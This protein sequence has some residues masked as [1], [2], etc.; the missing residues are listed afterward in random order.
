MP[1][2]VPTLKLPKPQFEQQVPSEHEHIRPLAAQNL[3]LVKKEERIEMS[4]M[5]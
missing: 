5:V 1:P 2:I 3:S 4:R